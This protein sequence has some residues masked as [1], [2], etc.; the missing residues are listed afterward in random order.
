MTHALIHTRNV[1]QN[2][3]IYLL[4]KITLLFIYL[5]RFLWIT[6]V[7]KC[8]ILTLAT[9]KYYR[10]SQLYRGLILHLTKYSIFFS[11]CFK[12]MQL[13]CA[14]PS[15]HSIISLST[16]CPNKNRKV[17]SWFFYT[18]AVL[19]NL[20][21]WNEALKSIVYTSLKSFLYELFL[22]SLQ[23][24]RTIWSNPIHFSRF[25]FWFRVSFLLFFILV[26][27]GSLLV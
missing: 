7:V 1:L 25:L 22:P 26:L 17:S 2:F 24:L 3:E 21:A 19:R 10:S 4:L 5:D 14:S 6:F 13:C 9:S 27:L 23:N 20:I 8:F 18:A 15:S 12:R 11:I 16:G